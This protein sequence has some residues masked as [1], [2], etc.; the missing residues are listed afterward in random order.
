MES[1]DEEFE[2]LIAEENRGILSSKIAEVSRIEDHA[3]LLQMQKQSSLFNKWCYFQFQA[4]RRAKKAEA[5]YDAALAEAKNDLRRN[6]KISVDAC[7]DRATVVPVVKVLRERCDD[8]EAYHTLFKQV[9]K[10]LA[11]KKDMLSSINSR[12]K[13]EM[14]IER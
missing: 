5:A 11:Q 4:E 6:G 1:W 7:K 3:V 10:G 9:V 14:E 12:Q 2:K 13:V 8:A